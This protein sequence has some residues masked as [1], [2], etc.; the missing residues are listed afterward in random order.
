MEEGNQ[1]TTN[2][3]Q[4]SADPRLAHQKALQP[5]ASFVA[6]VKAAQQPASDQVQPVP[7]SA[8][9]TSPQTPPTLSRQPLNGNSPD[10]NLTEHDTLPV[11]VSASQLGLNTPQHTGLN[12]K[13]LIKLS[14]IPCVLLALGLGA[15]IYFS[16]GYSYTTKTLE[17][18]GY[19]Y[20]FEFNR[21]ASVQ[22][23]K[24]KNYL[25]G[26]ALH[27]FQ[28]V[29]VL[30]EPVSATPP[31]SCSQEGA[32]M[33]QVFTTTINGTTYPVCSLHNAIYGVGF[34]FDGKNHLFE[35]ISKSALNIDTAETIFNS[36]T[37]ARK[38]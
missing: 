17:N 35:L 21:A 5:D 22:N 24:G 3:Q 1:Q 7:Q 25:N 18:G 26:W 34:A 13:K 2:P 27:S 9:Q 12:W 28:K 11:G 36:L 14:I 33:V 16:N 4:F 30:A 31:A 8:P 20:S 38:S 32:G 10:D 37:V 15:W 19:V 6:E 23:I 29:S